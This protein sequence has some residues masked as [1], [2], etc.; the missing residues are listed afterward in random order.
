MRSDY[1]TGDVEV[2]GGRLRV[3][4]WGADDA[5][6]VLAVHGVT[7][8]HRSW[9]LVADALPDVRLIAPDLRGRG[10]SGELPGPWGMAAHADDLAAV[11]ETMAVGPVLVV[12][13]SMGAF[14]AVATGER[15]PDLIGEVL[16]VDGGLPFTAPVD[17]GPAQ[18]RLAMTFESA[19]AHRDFWRQHPAL[20]DEWNPTIVDYVDYDLVGVAPRLHSSVS[21]DAVTADSAE[22]SGGDEAGL[23]RRL[24]LITV[25]RG[26]VDEPPGLYPEEVTRAWQARLPQLEVIRLADLNHYTVVLTPAGAGQVAAE[27]R[28][29]LAR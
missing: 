10:R 22:L 27:I 7:A 17:L 1:R 8:N 28:N 23:S 9:A 25:P 20:R 18:Q 4:V 2:K 29:L 19:T 6:V 11:L 24:S 3:G 15:H 13:H 12:G 21:I 14:V 26:L 16:L 5:P